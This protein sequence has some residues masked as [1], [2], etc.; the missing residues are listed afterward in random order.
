MVGQ[1]LGR[2][3]ERGTHIRARTLRVIPV[4]LLFGVTLWSVS[5]VSGFPREL[6][7]S[8]LLSGIDATWGNLRAVTRGLRSRPIDEYGPEGRSRGLG[9]LA[10]YVLTCTA[11]T[12]RLLVME[13]FEPQMAFYSERA[14]AGGQVHF[15]GGW[16]TSKA[17]QQLTIERLDRESVPIVIMGVRPKPGFHLNFPDVAVYVSAHYVQVAESAFGGRQ[18]W[19]VLVDTRRKPV[20]IDATLGLPCYR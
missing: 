11:P 16:H 1:W 20:G 14:F 19:R 10:R 15:L 8:A 6:R 18:P 12:D 13:A 4:L 3:V 5:T 2:R 7:R 17:D 9:S